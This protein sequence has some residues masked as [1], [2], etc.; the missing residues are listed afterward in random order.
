MKYVCFKSTP[1]LQSRFGKCYSCLLLLEGFLFPVL[2]RN[3][4]HLSGKAPPPRV[5]GQSWTP[6][7]PRPRPPWAGP[8]SFAGCPRRSW[9]RRWSRCSWPGAI[10]GGGN[11][12][13]AQICARRCWR[14]PLTTRY[15]PDLLSLVDPGDE[16]EG[17]GEY[18]GPRVWFRRREPRARLTLS[19]E[20]PGARPPGPLA[21]GSLPAVSP[22]PCRIHEP[23]ALSAP[24]PTSAPFLSVS[25]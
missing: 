15:W 6:P 8:G 7:G 14:S 9:A 19:A 18:S 24:S 10:L 17:S 25:P 23:C 20:A 21:G 16:A 2:R 1:F 5:A 22:S 3:A 13:S 12:S 11:S 4:E